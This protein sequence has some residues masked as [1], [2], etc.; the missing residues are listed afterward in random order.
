MSAIQRYVA[1]RCL[2]YKTVHIFA[3][4]RTCGQ[5]V[6]NEAENRVRDWGPTGV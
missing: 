2:D 4:S 3:Y 1:M 5:K 6:W